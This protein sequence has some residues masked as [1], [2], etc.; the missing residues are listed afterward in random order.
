MTH[1]RPLRECGRGAVR[2]AQMQEEEGQCREADSDP[3]TLK[4]RLSL[5]GFGGAA[6]RVCGFP[7]GWEQVKCEWSR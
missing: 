6:C 1:A 3:A 4:E 7:G 2:R 5:P